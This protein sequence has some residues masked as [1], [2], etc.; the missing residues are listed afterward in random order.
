MTWMQQMEEREEV[1]EEEEVGAFSAKRELIWCKINVPTWSP[2]LSSPCISFILRVTRTLT[3]RRTGPH[4]PECYC[5]WLPKLPLSFHL[6]LQLVC[7]VAPLVHSPKPLEALLTG[8]SMSHNPKRGNRAMDCRGWGS[9]FLPP[10]AVFCT[11]IYWVD[12]KPSLKSFFFPSYCVEY[13]TEQIWA[14]KTVS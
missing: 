10:F 9:H 13:K 12:C 11:F 7:V 3:H 8:R 1:M 4:T 2:S 6:A 14:D 5:Y